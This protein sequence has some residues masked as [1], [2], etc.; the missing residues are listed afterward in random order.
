MY[1]KKVKTWV[2]VNADVEMV[3]PR[4]LLELWFDE[5]DQKESGHVNSQSSTVYNGDDR[6]EE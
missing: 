5:R 2:V 4:N 6:A 3:V 1:M